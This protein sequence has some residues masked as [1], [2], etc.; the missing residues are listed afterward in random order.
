MAR[1]RDPSRDKAFEIWKQAVG[2]NKLKDI[3]EY[4]VKNTER[5]KQ[6][7]ALKPIKVIERSNKVENMRNN[8]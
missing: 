8:Q 3:T 7:N 1:A 4:L 5:S 6:W 2:D